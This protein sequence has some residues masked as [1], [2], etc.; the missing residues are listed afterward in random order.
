MMD[1]VWYQVLID[2]RSLHLE[3]MDKRVGDF[4]FYM[5]YI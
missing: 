1:S 3:S 4:L 5:D 2:S